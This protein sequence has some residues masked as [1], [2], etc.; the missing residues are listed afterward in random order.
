M[1]YTKI[2]SPPMDSILRRNDEE[3]AGMASVS[4]AHNADDFG[5][6]NRS[7]NALAMSTSREIPA[8]YAG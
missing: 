6:R 5:V 4:D 3:V 1:R 2:A 8:A 7:Q